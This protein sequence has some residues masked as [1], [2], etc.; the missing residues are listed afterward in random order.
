[1][2]IALLFLILL[3]S[4]VIFMSRVSTTDVQ[5]SGNEKAQTTAFYAADAGAYGSAKVVG[6]A[7][8][9]GTKPTFNS[10]GDDFPELSFIVPDFYDQVMGFNQTDPVTNLEFGGIGDE[11]IEF[12]LNGY[13]VNVDIK[14]EGTRGLAGG[15]A[16][17]GA[18]SSGIGAGSAGGV[19]IYY[20]ARSVGEGPKNS[21]SEINVEYRKIPGT[22]GGL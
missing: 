3:T 18:G 9:I 16:E 22:A 13:E 8:E 4:M 15:G 19:A 17:F 5:I 12:F 14:N 6:R 21:R 1:M 10:P 20:T 7:I 11:D 2:N